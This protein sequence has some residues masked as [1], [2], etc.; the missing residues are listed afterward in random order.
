MNIRS[1][2]FRKLPRGIVQISLLLKFQKNKFK[3]NEV[4]AYQETQR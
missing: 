4:T 2:N 3:D 1:K